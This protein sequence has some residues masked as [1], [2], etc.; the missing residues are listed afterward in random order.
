MKV[1]YISYMVIYVYTPLTLFYL[2]LRLFALEKK[3]EE[4]KKVI[5]EVRAAKV[6]ANYFN[7]LLHLLAHF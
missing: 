3:W 2:M 4:K 7:N 1:I 6:F 5:K